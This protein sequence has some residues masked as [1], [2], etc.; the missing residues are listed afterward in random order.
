MSRVLSGIVALATV[1]TCWC[2]AQAQCPLA[3]RHGAGHGGV[4]GQALTTWDPIL[5][6]ILSRAT[7]P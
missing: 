2:Q 7:R 6:G 4:V 5:S 3:W 1:C